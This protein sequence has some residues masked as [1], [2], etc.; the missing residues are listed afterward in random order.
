MIKKII[1]LFILSSCAQI[2]SL[3]LKKHQ[4]GKI[5]TKIVWI[6]IAGFTQEHLAMLK[7]DNKNSN[8]LNSFE[9]SLCIG[10]AWEYSLFDLRPT[11]QASFMSQVTGKKN[12]KNTCEDLNLKPMWAYGK[13]ANLKVGIFE[14]ELN[15]DQSLLSLIDECKKQ[16]YLSPVVYWGMRKNIPKKSKLFHINETVEF[17]KGSRYFDKSCMSGNCSTSLAKNI[18]QTFLNFQKNSSNYIYIVRDFSYLNALQSKDIRQ[19]KK[20][21]IELERTLSFFQKL[22]KKNSDML[23]LATTASGVVIDFPRK[24]LGWKNFDNRKNF[25]K[26]KNT[27]LISNVYATGARAEN[28]CGIYDQSQIMSRIYSGAKQQGLEFSIINP[29]EQN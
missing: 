8:Q 9:N 20:E 24:G 6:Q 18:E 10:E 25:L 12:I 3:N 21:L 14:S 13:N 1:L 29:F 5:P 27:K 26:L 22:A 16:D 11:A 15:S 2:T 4:F 19:V 23:V 28:F 17:D 7:F